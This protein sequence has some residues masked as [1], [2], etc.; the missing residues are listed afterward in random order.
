[1][2]LTANNKHMFTEA[3]LEYDI[4]ISEFRTDIEIAGSPE[5]SELRAVIEDT[6]KRLYVL[7]CVFDEDV[8]KKKNIASY[9]TFLSEKNIPEI[10]PYLQTEESDSL[11]FS[12]DRFWMI[13]SYIKGVQLKRPEYVFEKWRGKTLNVNITGG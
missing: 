4:R 1:M 10:N 13:S 11:V 3:A 12:Q 2:T 9:L 5:R 8:K 6:D 7:E